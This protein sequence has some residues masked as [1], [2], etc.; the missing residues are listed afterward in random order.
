VITAS[1]L[2]P[3]TD[4][5]FSLSAN[6]STDTPSDMESLV[7]YWDLDVTDDADSDGFADNDFDEQGIEIWIDIDDSGTHEIRLMVFDDNGADGNATIFIEV[8]SVESGFLGGI[9]NFEDNGVAIIVIILLLVLGGLL[10]I[11]AISSMRSKRA[12]PWDTIA[13]GVP[14]DTIPSS[15]PQSDMFAAPA[16]QLPEGSPPVIEAAATPHAET[17]Q[18]VQSGPPPIPAT[19]LPEGWTEEQ[20]SYYG[21]QWL[22]KQAE[23][24]VVETPAPV[25]ETPTPTWPTSEGDMDLDL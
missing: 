14:M 24:P 5:K 6:L 12:D 25:A 10:G 7:F 17:I 16:A 22:E 23:T 11:L 20:W 8:Q 3:D 21:A 15:A 19:G 13:A 4:E 2:T 18:P 1:T 9:L